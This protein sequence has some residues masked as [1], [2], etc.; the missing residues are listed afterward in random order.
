MDVWREWDGELQNYQRV[1]GNPQIELRD[2]NG[3]GFRGH[4]CFLESD[5]NAAFNPEARIEAEPLTAEAPQPSPRKR[6]SGP[7]HEAV[8]RALEKLYPK[9]VPD[10]SD[11]P[12]K[13]FCNKVRNRLKNV[14]SMTPRS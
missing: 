12:N 4:I 6:K 1:V 11:L 2:V 7:K 3:Q 9:G 14:H 8:K 10:Q 13:V 5:L